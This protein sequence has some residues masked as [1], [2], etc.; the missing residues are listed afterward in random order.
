MIVRCLYEHRTMS[1]YEV[2]FPRNNILLTKFVTII[3]QSLLKKNDGRTIIVRASYEQH[4]RDIAVTAPAFVL[5]KNNDDR[6]MH[7]RSL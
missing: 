7:V 1:L 3:V 2:F 4:S 5:A 6:T